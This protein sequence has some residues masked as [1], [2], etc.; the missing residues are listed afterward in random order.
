MRTGRVAA[1]VYVPLVPL[2]TPL[3]HP[4]L[5]PMGLGSE[6]ARTRTQ[7]PSVHRPVQYPSSPKPHSAQPHRRRPCPVASVALGLGRRLGA[8]AGLGVGAGARG[9]R[10]GGVVFVQSDMER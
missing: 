5:V 10:P 7:S 3:P 6:R 9:P 2:R 4:I 1:R 8:T